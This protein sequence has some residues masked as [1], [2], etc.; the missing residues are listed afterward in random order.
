MRSTT[1]KIKRIIKYV[2][3]CAN[4]HPY[5][6]WGKIQ[7]WWICAFIFK[8]KNSLDKSVP[9]A[10]W[11]LMT[12]GYSSLQK[13]EVFVSGVKIFYGSQTG[14]AKVRTSYTFLWV[15]WSFKKIPEKRPLAMNWIGLPVFFQLVFFPFSASIFPSWDSGWVLT[16][17]LF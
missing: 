11:G 17:C 6:N 3:I 12:N 2:S 4:F 8:D 1:R 7:T 13:K 14:T 10:T 9:K 16:L 5:W 15:S